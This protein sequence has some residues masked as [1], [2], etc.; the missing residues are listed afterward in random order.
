VPSTFRCGFVGLVGRPNAG[1]STLLNRLLGS[2]LAITSAKPQTTRNR[3]SAIL[4]DEHAQA[5]LVDT[6][7]IHDAQTEINKEMVA[8]ALE[9]IPEV[10][11]VVIVVDAAHA[12]HR[13]ETGR[14]A[15]DET[16]DR[17]A[18]ALGGPTG[19]GVVLACNK[20][21]VVPRPLMLPVID[22][23]QQHIALLAAVPISALTGDGVDAL[24]AQ[25]TKNLPVH[26]PLYPVDLLTE[27]SERFFAA[28]VVREK[29]FHLTEEEVPY[30]TFVEVTQF[31]EE[32]RDSRGLV[33]IMA[34]IVVERDG[35]KRII[36]GRG[37]EMIKRI[38][39]ASRKDI[40]ALL[41]CRV[42]LELFV[43]VEPNWSR[44]RGG[45]RRIGFRA[46]P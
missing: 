38:G 25:I 11:V 6:P 3:I 19:R 2:K 18:A 43:K 12:A 23:W 8:V 4:T 14:P 36:I 20:A 21:D 37:G 1:K 30:A 31:D 41:G 39:V 22:A 15:L 16:D 13:V 40:E 42:H 10:D 27:H 32:E 9:S 45:L 33:R 34:D 35:Q 17:I 26:P 28:E 29:I 24:R 7:G 5:I 46:R 44:T